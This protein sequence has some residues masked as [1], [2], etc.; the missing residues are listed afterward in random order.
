MVKTMIRISSVGRIAILAA[1]LALGGA[2]GRPSWAPVPAPVLRVALGEMSD[3]LLTG[4]RVVPKVAESQGYRF[5]H[6]KLED[7]LRAVVGA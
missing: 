5:R 3:M 2:L 7:A 4:Q 6:P 1:G